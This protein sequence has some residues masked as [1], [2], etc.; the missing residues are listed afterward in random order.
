[1]EES[2][3]SIDATYNLNFIDTKE[4]ELEEININRRILI[5]DDE[6]FNVIGLKIILIQ[7]GYKNLEKIIDIAYNG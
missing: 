1:M 7:L 5:V 6:P 2:D 4:L 3:E